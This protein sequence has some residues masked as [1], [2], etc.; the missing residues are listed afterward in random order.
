MLRL[1]PMSIIPIQ[2]IWQLYC[3]AQLSNST[4]DMDFECSQVMTNLHL[5][6]LYFPILSSKQKMILNLKQNF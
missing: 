5:C 1:T 4:A 6:L 3:N 2:Y